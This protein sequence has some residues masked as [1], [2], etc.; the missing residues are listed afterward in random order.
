MVSK[1]ALFGCKLNLCKSV[2]KTLSFGERIILR[3]LARMSNSSDYDMPMTIWHD[4]YYE[5]TMITPWQI[6]WHKKYYEITMITPWQI[7]WHNKW[8]RHQ[9][10][11]HK[12]LWTI[13]KRY[14][15]RAGTFENKQ[16]WNV[17]NM[18]QL[19]KLT[20]GIRRGY[21]NA[22]LSAASIDRRIWRR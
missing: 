22:W 14:N 16:H 18:V 17:L 19:V 3:T 7:L 10:L 2:M 21:K 1:L 15:F 9:L 13:F 20:T 5:I 12:E 11:R 8:P 6:L 4:K